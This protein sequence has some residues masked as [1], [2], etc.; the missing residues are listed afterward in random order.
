VRTLKTISVLLSFLFFPGSALAFDA[1][2][3]LALNLY[4]SKIIYAESQTRKKQISSSYK[5]YKFTDEIK[6]GINNIYTQ[7][8]IRLFKNLPRERNPAHATQ[9]TYLE[10]IAPQL[11]WYYHS[12]LHQILN[13]LG[14]YI[15]KVTTV[16]DNWSSNHDPNYKL[17]GYKLSIASNF[18]I[19]PELKLYVELYFPKFNIDMGGRFI[20]NE[21]YKTFVGFISFNFQIQ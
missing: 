3:N 20:D 10:N 9:A 17:Q 4:S 1:P 16:E 18:L 15:E 2:P 21:E 5:A 12:S 13:N 11:N 19:P 8:N 14:Y 7:R 6:I